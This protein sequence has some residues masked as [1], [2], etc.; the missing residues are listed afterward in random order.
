MDKETFI[1]I[2][3][4]YVDTRE[5]ISWHKYAPCA[6][7]KYSHE[8]K[9]F[10]RWYDQRYPGGSKGIYYPKYVQLFAKAKYLKIF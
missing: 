9:L 7:S 2:N 10:K 5:D 8:Y 4:K 6:F 3:W 1:N